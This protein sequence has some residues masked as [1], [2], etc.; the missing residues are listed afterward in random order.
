LGRISL[1]NRP[2]VF[3]R[4]VDLINRFVTQTWT[5]ENQNDANDEEEEEEEEE[6][7]EE[8]VINNAEEEEET[9]SSE[10]DWDD[11]DDGEDSVS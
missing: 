10:F 4:N 8:V 3:N 11:Y 2:M 5:T 1:L 6:E 7:D 9:E